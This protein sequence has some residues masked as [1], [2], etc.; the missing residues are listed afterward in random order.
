MPPENVLPPLIVITGPTATGKSA[1]GVEVA[2]QLGGEIISADSI[3]IYRSMNIGTAKPTLEERQG[4]PHYMIDLVDPDEKYS[5]ALYQSQATKCI[6][7]IIE[8]GKIPLLVGGTGLYIRAL[9][10]QYS[11][12]GTENNH[13]FRQSLVRQAQKYGQEALHARLAQIDPVTATRLHPNDLKRVI[14]ALEVYYLTGKPF[15]YFQ[16][17]G[18][19]CKYNL[20]MYGINMER[21]LLYRKIEERVDKMIRLGLVEEVQNLLNKGYDIGLTSLQGL[22]YKEIITY[23]KGENTLAEAIYLL[24]RNTRRFAKRQLTWFKKD[25]RILWLKVEKNNISEVAQNIAG[26]YKEMSKIF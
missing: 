21:Q 18:Q 25:Q 6:E 22:G 12:P 5:V 3:L 1:L 15:S 19:K 24:K 23:L 11:F 7:D 16:K 20:I 13:E 26:R 2:K 17:S 10:E 14:R 4:I 9:T 8:R